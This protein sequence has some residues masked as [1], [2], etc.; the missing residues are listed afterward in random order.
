MKNAKIFLV[1]HSLFTGL[2]GI[3]FLFLPEFIFS[4]TTLQASSAVLYFFQL[5]GGLLLGLAMLSWTSRGQPIGGIYARPL[6]LT[7]FTFL[8]VGLLSSLK[9][10]TVLVQNGPLGILVGLYVFLFGVAF[11]IL[12]FKSPV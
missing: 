11:T 1:A 4:H 2:L 7:N 3:I 6:V 9:M 5:F 12:L 10:P 8:L